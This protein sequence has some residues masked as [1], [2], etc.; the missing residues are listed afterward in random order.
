MAGGRSAFQVERHRL[1]VELKRVREAAGLT[2]RDMAGRMGVS[3]T[4]VVHLETG[5]RGAR[6]DDVAAWAEAAG[7][8][9]DQAAALTT[10]AERAQTD[11]ANW[12]L[13][14]R[15]AG[16]AGMA[17]IQREWSALERLA[18]IFREYQ[19]LIVPGLL[20]TAE[21]ARRTFAA[22]AEEGQDLAAAAAA[23]LERQAALYDA[24]KRFEFLVCEA[25]LRWRI[26][27][28]AV[29]AAQL[30]RI[31]Q[32]MT[33]PSVYMG[34]IPVDVEAAIWRYHPFAMLDGP[35]DYEGPAGVWVETLDQNVAVADAEVVDRYRQAFRRLQAVAATGDQAV[36]ILDRT[37][38]GLR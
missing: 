24:S 11:V 18:P 38:S 7:L 17:D 32:V 20:Q 31:R 22:E 5:R 8:P 4:K 23:R 1:A 37:A 25:A 29:Q 16:S 36:E 27:P 26:G 2:T 6:P 30:D 3:Q 12:R 15:E 33:L 14:M 13:A 19:L 35:D 10:R 9:D 28:P 34:V 21:Y